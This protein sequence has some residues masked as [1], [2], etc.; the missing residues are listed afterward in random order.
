[1]KE[2]PTEIKISQLYKKIL[3][4][5]PDKNGLEYYTKQLVSGTK[6]LNDVEKSLP[7]FGFSSKSS[8]RD[9][10]EIPLQCSSRL[11][12][13]LFLLLEECI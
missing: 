12:Q 8:V 11:D 10:L 9:F 6:T 4:R 1:M 5:T 7:L 2:E 3:G 13:T